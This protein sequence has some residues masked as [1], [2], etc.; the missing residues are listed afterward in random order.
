MALGEFVDGDEK[1]FGEGDVDADGAR[2]NVVADQD[3]SGFIDF[4]IGGNRVQGRC[5]RKRLIILKGE[6]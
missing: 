2:W 5:I 1:V 6:R 3:A 4:G